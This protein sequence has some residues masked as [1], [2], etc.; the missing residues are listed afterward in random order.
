MCR[1]EKVELPIFI[2]NDTGYDACLKLSI[3]I[4]KDE[5]DT[6]VYSEKYIEERLLPYKTGHLEVSL[7]LPAEYGNWRFE[8]ILQNPPCD[9]EH[10]VISS[11]RFRTID[12]RADSSL[13][14]LAIGVP[15]QE[16]EL[17]QFFKSMGLEVNP[18][19]THRADIIV[20]GRKTWGCLSEELKNRL[21][22]AIESG[23]SVIMLDIGPIELGR[24]YSSVEDI[25]E[26]EVTRMGGV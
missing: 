21:E 4:V 20:T 1:S 2:F 13:K 9:I 11:W 12:A 23:C 8:G 25:G 17:A 10:P 18:V 22:N 3:R 15:R 19:E 6:T 14:G 16:E 24:E 7:E 5:A 26:A